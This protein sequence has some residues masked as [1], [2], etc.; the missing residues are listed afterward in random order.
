ML[1]ER[2]AAC[3]CGSH[4]LAHSDASLFAGMV[5]D[6]ICFQH[7]TTFTHISTRFHPIEH[8]TGHTTANQAQDRLVSDGKPVDIPMDGRLLAQLQGV[9]RN[10]ES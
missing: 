7:L 4:H 8:E 1:F 9:R 3:T 10:E 6:G 5:Q 2:V